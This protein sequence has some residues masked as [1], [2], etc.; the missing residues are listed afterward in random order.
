MEK[1]IKDRKSSVSRRFRLMNM[2]QYYISNISLAFSS[3]IELLTKFHIS[4]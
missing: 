3:I 2:K 1:S 4:E